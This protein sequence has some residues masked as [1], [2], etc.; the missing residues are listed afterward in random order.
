M[1]DMKDTSSGFVKVDK[2]LYIILRDL[3]EQK[4]LD[5]SKNYIIIFEHS[6]SEG[7]SQVFGP[8]DSY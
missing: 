1:M 6:R 8:L 4:Y 2:D 7:T 3:R 5:N